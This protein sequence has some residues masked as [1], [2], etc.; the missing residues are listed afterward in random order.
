MQQIR[1]I[2]QLHSRGEKIRAISRQINLDRNTVRAY[3]RRCLLHNSDVDALLGLS[4]EALGQ[5]AYE[6][7][8][9]KKKGDKRII[10]LEGRLPE[11]VRE[12]SKTGVTRQLLWQE[13][14]Q[15]RPD[16]YGYTQ[17]CERLK[18]YARKGDAVM[19]FEHKAAERLMIDFAGKML[20]YVDNRTGEVVDC[21]V[22]V[23]VLPFSGY[24]YV[25]ALPSQCQEDFVAAIVN[26]FAYL[27]G[28][29]ACV[30]I[31]NLKS[32][33]KRANR[34]E[35]AF[36]ELLEQL[37]LHYGCS[38]MAT[39]VAKPRDKASVERE[40]QLAYQRIYAPL[41]NEHFSSLRGVNLAIKEQLAKHHRQPFQRKAGSNRLA[42]FQQQERDLL[43]ALPAGAFAVKYSIQAKVQ[44]NYHIVIGQDWHYYSVP[45]EYIHK[46]VQV[47]YTSKEVEVYYQHERIA[48]HQRSRVKY[49]YTTLPGHMPPAHRHYLEQRGWTG[50]HFLDQASR[51]GPSCQR[52]I[53]QILSGK[54]FIEQTYNSC[55]GVLRLAGKYGDA[56]LEAACCRALRGHRINYMVICNILHHNLDKLEQPPEPLSQIPEH[57]NIRGPGAYQ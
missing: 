13:Y 4:D 9:E 51:I 6:P 38:F 57:D 40:V 1:L 49:G 26:C 34:Y 12:L 44:R 36:T 29:P 27:G 52:A 10:D 37:S 20:S 54:M 24:S 43:K 50:E 56:R 32:G 22:F 19:H 33:V 7:A 25:E 45:H 31:D 41:R 47:V 35:P 8:I 28:V 53:E 23:A 11:L 3:L 16:G 17:F 5:I 55:L 2:L 21:P 48:L 39:R 42:L 30:L 46:K 18:A 14:R 15:S